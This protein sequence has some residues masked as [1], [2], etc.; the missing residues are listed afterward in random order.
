MLEYYNNIDFVNED[1]TLNLIASP[2][3]QTE[4]LLKKGLKLNGEYQI[5]KDLTIFPEKM[6]TGKNLGTRRIRLMPYTRSIHH[7]EGSWLDIRGKKNNLQLELDI[8]NYT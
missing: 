8:N 3:W 5:V 6:L 1:G 7:Y 2:V 4:L